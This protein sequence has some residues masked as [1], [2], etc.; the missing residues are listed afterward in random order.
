M[1]K[2]ILAE[3]EGWTP[4]IDDMCKQHGL[5]RA[6]V[7]GRVWRFCQGADNVCNAS[8]NR[9]A[10]DLGLDRSTVL[11]HIESLVENGYLVKYPSPK[12][13]QPHTYADTGKA[14][15]KV[16]ISVA[17]NNT[18]VAE[19]HLKKQEKQKET[20]ARRKNGAHPPDPRKDHPAIVSFRENAQ[21]YPDKLAW[22]DIIG[23]VGDV[24]G[25]VSLW[26]QVVHAY[27]LQ[28]WNKRNIGNMLEFY[29]RGE[30][31]AARNGKEKS[32]EPAGFA[33]IR[34]A[35]RR[36]EESELTWGG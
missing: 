12:F 21:S 18:S 10:Q 33:G 29:R 34:E 13:K 7:F 26:G 35:R 22:D 15:L 31:P 25:D 30:I 19:S 8:L 36:R 4:L 1:S 24:P 11:R 5:V 20:L 32:N 27:A 9:I 3:I 17:Q 2:T 23:T 6:A 16:N 14:A 28:G